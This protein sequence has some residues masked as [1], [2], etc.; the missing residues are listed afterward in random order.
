MIGSRRRIK[1]GI[2]EGFTVLEPMLGKS[3]ASAIDF[4]N[5]PALLECARVFERN[6]EIRDSPSPG[7]TTLN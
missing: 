2:E 7:P 1:G 6:G 3:E 4:A 5:A